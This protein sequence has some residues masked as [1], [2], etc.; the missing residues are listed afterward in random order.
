MLVEESE[1]FVLK[2]TPLES[3]TPVSFRLAE[4][5][6]LCRTS[7]S[8]K[9]VGDDRGFFVAGSLKSPTLRLSRI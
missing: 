5:V 2:T 1:Y 6:G 9:E 8:A 3:L 4:G 7:L